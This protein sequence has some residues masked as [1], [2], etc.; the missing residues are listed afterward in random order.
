MTLFDELNVPLEISLKNMS[1]ICLPLG[2][3]ISKYY[4]FIII[5]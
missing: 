3:S 5:L 1:F 2:M 4:Y